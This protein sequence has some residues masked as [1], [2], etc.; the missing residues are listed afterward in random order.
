MK[1]AHQV[2]RDLGLLLRADHFQEFVIVEAMQVLAEA[3]T[4]H[5]RT[6]YDQFRDHY[7]ER[8]VRGD[9]PLAGGPETAGEDTERRRDVR[10]IAGAGPRAV[11]A[12]A[13]AARGRGASLESLFLDEGFGRSTRRRWMR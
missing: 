7:R 2:A 11:G 6:L 5:L 10:G 12:A 3:A 1:A 9:R 8:R 13:G 4:A